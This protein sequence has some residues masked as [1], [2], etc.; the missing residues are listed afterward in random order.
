[1]SRRHLLLYEIGDAD[2]VAPAL[3]SRKCEEPAACISF[4]V[5]SIAAET[6]E[7]SAVSNRMAPFAAGAQF[8]VPRQLARNVLEVLDRHVIYID[9]LP[10]FACIWSKRE[11]EPFVLSFL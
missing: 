3:F 1:M 5:A 6:R 10:E 11:A 7:R 2:G 8:N 9:A 4:Y